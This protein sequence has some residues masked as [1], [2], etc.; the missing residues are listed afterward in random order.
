MT[1]TDDF[2]FFALQARADMRHIALSAG[3]AAFR[4]IAGQL[5]GRG[6]PAAEPLAQRLSDIARGKAPA[7]ALADDDRA[8]AALLLAS[9]APM[10]DGDSFLAA[11]AI[12]LLHRLDMRGGPD[13]LLWSRPLLFDTLRRQ[14]S[15][16]RA[17]V[18]CAIRG[19]RRMGLIDLGG[20]PNPEDCLTRPRTQVLTSLRARPGLT[21]IARAIETASSPRTAGALW[22][23]WS[24]RMAS[25]D[26]ADRRAAVA[27]FRYLY[28]RRGGLAPSA[29]TS[30]IP[31]A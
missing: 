13:D 29:A 23:A 15:P 22:E 30:A 12:L 7:G 27:G 8:L 19:A 14:P 5:D 20:D 1:R 24:D 16:A 25:L 6:T 3:T 2:W 28:E 31:M 26:P 4:R 9:A 21:A 10:D 11:T 18:M 17:A